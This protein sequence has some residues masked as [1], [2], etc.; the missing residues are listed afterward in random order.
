MA[1][2]TDMSEYVETTMSG[3]E[4]N[5]I[6]ADFEFVKVTQEDEICDD[7][8]FDDDSTSDSAIE[9][10]NGNIQ[11]VKKDSVQDISLYKGHVIICMRKITVPDDAV[12]HINSDRFEVNKVNLYPRVKFTQKICLDIVALNGLAL[13][14]LPPFMQDDKHVCITA[15]RQNGDALKFIRISFRDHDMCVVAIRQTARAIHYVPT[16]M[17]S[18]GMRALVSEH[19]QNNSADYI[20]DEL[21]DYL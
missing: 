15:L 1:T 3:Y 2:K 11:F 4:F 17:I 18:D 8:Q 10:Y 7:F 12:I 16:Y 21:I 6:Y 20:S 5:S 9:G 19:I 13:Q 14:Y